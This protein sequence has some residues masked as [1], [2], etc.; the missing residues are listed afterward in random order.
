MDENNIVEKFK[1]FFLKT[2]KE[3]RFEYGNFSMADEYLE[4]IQEIHKFTNK[5]PW[6]EWICDLYRENRN[7]EEFVIGL[8]KALGHIKVNE[9][10]SECIEI[11]KDAIENESLEIKENAVRAFENWEYT[12]AIP[13]LETALF[14]D[15]FLDDYLRQVIEGLKELKKKVGQ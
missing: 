9:L 2:I 4:L 6:S 15:L 14:D 12:D 10:K 8:L 5:L 1:M 3:S 11:V 7:D 13:I